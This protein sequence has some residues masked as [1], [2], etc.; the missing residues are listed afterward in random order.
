MQSKKHCN[1]SKDSLGTLL[2]MLMCLNQRCILIPILENICCLQQ[3]LIS[4]SQRFL[5]VYGLSFMH[6]DHGFSSFKS[7]IFDIKQVLKSIH[8]ETWAWKPKEIKPV[9]H[10]TKW[11]HLLILSQSWMSITGVKYQKPFRTKIASIEQQAYCCYCL[12][13]WKKTPAERGVMA[14]IIFILQKWRPGLDKKWVL[15]M[16]CS[17]WNLIF[18][19]ARV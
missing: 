10:R 13:R 14:K 7:V 17:S 3:L 6:I 5:Q 16:N 2:T 4:L 8:A 18:E 1:N 9:M 12:G 11:Y 15:L 19:G